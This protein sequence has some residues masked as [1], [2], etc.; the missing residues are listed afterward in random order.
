MVRRTGSLCGRGQGLSA[1]VFD[2][3]SDPSDEQSVNQRGQRSRV[4]TMTLRM[5]TCS[6]GHE[7]NAADRILPPYAA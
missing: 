4:L 5:A 3:I 2:V 6:F 7:Q 1:T